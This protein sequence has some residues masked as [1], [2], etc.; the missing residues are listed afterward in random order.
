MSQT[1]AQ[2]VTENG[3]NI[4][5]DIADAVTVKISGRLAI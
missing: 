5:A 2:L 3:L 1:K 4:N